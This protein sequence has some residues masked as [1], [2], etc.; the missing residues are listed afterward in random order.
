MKSLPTDWDEDDAEAE[1]LRIEEE[2]ERA[3]YLADLRQS[4]E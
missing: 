2:I 1:R 3:E 4:G